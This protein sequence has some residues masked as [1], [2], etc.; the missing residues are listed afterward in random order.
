MPTLTLRSGRAVTVA[1]PDLY[2]LVA[3][4]PAD[5]GMLDLP[6][7]ALLA[8]TDLIVYGANLTAPPA[9]EARLAENRAFLQTQYE[10]AALC[11][12]APRLVLRGPA[13]AD[14]LT[15]RDLHPADLAVLLAWFQNGGS[16][17]APAAAHSQ[18]DA[19]APADP[20]GAAPAL[21]PERAAGADGL[22]GVPL[23]SGA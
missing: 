14:D 10:I 3:A 8:I 11:L 19:G 2:A 4:P 7:A 13:A 23:G 9:A 21:P 22:A 5:P 6:N 1:L 18:P 16:V 15:P 17:G 20:D 12:V